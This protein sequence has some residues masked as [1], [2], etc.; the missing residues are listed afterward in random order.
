MGH[1]EM[2]ISFLFTDISKTVI[3]IPAYLKSSYSYIIF[4]LPVPLL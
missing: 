3:D 1:I 2:L 4:Y